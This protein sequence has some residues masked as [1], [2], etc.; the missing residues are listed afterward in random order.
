MAKTV[1][2]VTLLKIAL[3]AFLLDCFIDVAY[4]GISGNTDV[5]GWGEERPI[6]RPELMVQAMI[7]LPSAIILLPFTVL[8]SG[9]HIDRLMFN[10]AFGFFSWVG[11]LHYPL[12]VLT[13]ILKRWMV[14]KIG[15]RFFRN[16]FF[17]F[18]LLSYCLPIQR[19]IFAVFFVT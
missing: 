15:Y 10:G 2:N 13:I 4:V 11:L 3:W 19:V 6:T 16:A 9:S 1:T 18:C 7:Y 5:F 14:A 12:L 17:I 8:M